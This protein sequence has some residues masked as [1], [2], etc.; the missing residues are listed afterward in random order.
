MLLR[1]LPLF[2]CL[3][4]AVS[5]QETPLNT[6]TEEE[7]AEGWRL[8]F[9][10]KA[11]LGLRGVQKPDFLRGGWKID[12]GALTLPKSIDQMGRVTG[13]DI[14]T[15]EQYTDFEL[16]FEY[17]MSVSGDGGI[18]YFARA[19][20]GQP[21]TGCRFQIIDDVHHPDGLKGGPIR[22]TGALYGVLPPGENKR[23][24]PM[25]WN[26]ARLVV[27]GNH[28][29]HWVNGEKVLEYEAGSPALLQAV[30]ASKLRLS[31]SYGFKIKS[32]L[33]FMD[34]GSEVAFRNLKIRPLPPAR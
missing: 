29:E 6:L 21:P 32:P 13:G 20:L 24:D 9:D 3:L 1:I 28:V 11:A 18:L 10:G 22:R 15:V 33:I 23:I 17:Q 16:S 7:R 8:L 5:A 4:A 14:M 2:L 31:P 30:R 25:G 12:S 27:Q 34:H 26:S 19:M